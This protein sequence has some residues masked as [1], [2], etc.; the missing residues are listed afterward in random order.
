[1]TEHE[2]VQTALASLPRPTPPSRLRRAVMAQ[3]RRESAIQVQT[4]SRTEADG[5]TT[6]RWEGMGLPG[7][8]APTPTPAHVTYTRWRQDDASGTTIYQFTQTY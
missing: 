3:V 7:N 5:W 6:E 2:L 1:M 8:T 4:W